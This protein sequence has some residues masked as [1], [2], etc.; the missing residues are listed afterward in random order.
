MPENKI[1]I[2]LPTD[3]LENQP[4][5]QIVCDKS[6]KDD[7]V[8][9]NPPHLKSECRIPVSGFAL[10]NLGSHHTIILVSKKL[11][12][13]KVDNSSWVYKRGGHKAN[14]CA[15]GWKDRWAS[16]GSLGF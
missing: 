12:R 6:R 11:N 3:Y 13:L 7:I 14:H 2:L 5:I 10:K 16:T 4:V 8:I 15:Q 9:Q 1:S